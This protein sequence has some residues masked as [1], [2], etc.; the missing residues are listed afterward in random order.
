MKVKFITSIYSD[1]HGTEFGGRPSRGGHY[2]FSLLSLLKMTNADFLCYTSENELESL[3]EFFYDNYDISKEQ[4]KF[5]V[6]DISKSK[7]SPLIDLY[8]NVEDTKKSDRCVE[9]QYSKFSWFLDEDGSYDYYYWIDAGLSHCGIIPDKYLVDNHSVGKYYEC[10]LFDNNFLKNLIEFTGDKF[11]LL[12]KENQ[13][14]YWSGTVD[15]KWYKKYSYDLHIIGGLFGGKK[16]KWKE[17]VDI[18]EKN[19]VE[20]S[21]DEKKIFFEENIMSLMFYNNLN[22]FNYKEFD[23]WWHE[24]NYREH[25]EDFFKK[26]KS[27]YKILEE[28]NNVENKQKNPNL[29]ELTNKVAYDK[30]NLTELANKF[31]S[32]KGN[33]HFECH[34]YTEIYEKLLSPYLDK[35]VKM[36]EIGVNDVRFPCA[37]INMW[38]SFFENLSFF[39][40]D[41][42]PA[43]KEFEKEN[44]KII[45]GDQGNSEDLKKIILESGGEFDIILDD[46]SHEHLH[47]ILT[48]TTLKDHLKE[49]GIYIIED[50]HAYD[51]HLTKEWFK[52]KG[53]EH[54]LY[55]NEKLLIYKK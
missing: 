39:G 24:D 1:L 12:A 42:N 17:I 26:N 9:I 53:I 22:L 46:G 50:L 43:S 13:R 21:N 27:F 14:N 41:I 19:I 29:T 11:F 20:I 45:I 16:E 4:L 37:S 28:F 8:K 51:C 30:R 18:F 15:P 34:F 48:F 31:G 35:H 47:H 3:K 5:K 6:F 55:C 44:V 25:S 32:D 36:L 54:K 52:S 33:M 49:G 10:V 23:V 38:T 40:F 7:F 2:R